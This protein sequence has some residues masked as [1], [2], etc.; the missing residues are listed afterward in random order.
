M[1]WSSL[2]GGN[3]FDNSTGITSLKWAST[4][5][6]SIGGF[7]YSPSEHHV[8]S[9]FSCFNIVRYVSSLLFIPLASYIA[10]RDFFFCPSM[11][12]CQKCHHKNC[13]YYLNIYRNASKT[14][15]SRFGSL[16]ITNW[17]SYDDCIRKVSPARIN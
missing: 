3:A 15:A 5:P 17:S 8:R 4:F 1:T 14:L 7:P 11:T 2:L 9:T 13:L 10:K 16:V 6:T 12:T